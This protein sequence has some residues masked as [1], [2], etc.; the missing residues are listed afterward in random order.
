M[1]ESRIYKPYKS[2]GLTGL[3][4]ISLASGLAIALL[5]AAPVQAEE[6]AADTC[7]NAAKLFKDG[8]L[9]GAL[10]DA[11]WCVTELEKLKKGQT[12]SLFKDEIDGYTGDDISEQQAM[13][14]SIIERRYSKDG[15]SINVS[16]SGGA[17]GMAN[18][19]FA[20]IAAM[21]MQVA[22]GE[23]VRIQRRTAMVSNNGSETTI[24]VT[25]KSGGILT[26]NSS[27]VDKDKMLKFANAFPVAEVDD[28]LR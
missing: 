23:K 22:E 15:T 3:K 17:L 21:G 16:M 1:S 9:D 11:R 13:G 19:A 24:A 28:S 25:L 20:A 10:D 8:D 27:D 18:S 5:A 14:V 6:D 7:K 12:T 26:F 2:A 4:F